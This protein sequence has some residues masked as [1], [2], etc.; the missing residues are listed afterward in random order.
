M[1]RGPTKKHHRQ[2]MPGYAFGTLTCLATETIRSRASAD[3]PLVLNIEPTNFCN[4]KCYLCAGR[5]KAT[6]PR[7]FM[8]FDIFKEIIDEC[9]EHR[10]LH[11]LNLH[12]D[13]ESFLHPRIFDMIRYAKNSKCAG[14]I[15][16]NTNGTLLDRYEPKMVLESGLDDITIS[17]D[18]LLP[19]TYARIKRADSLD[20]VVANTLSLLQA[21]FQMKIR[22]PRIRVKIMEFID[23]KDEI[24]SFVEF[25]K[26]KADEVQVTGAHDWS[27]AIDGLHVTDECPDVRWPCSLLWYTLA[28]NW[29]GQVS[30]CNLDWDLSGAV[31]NVLYDNIESIWRGQK[32]RVIRRAALEGKYEPAVCGKC[33]VW[34][35]GEDMTEWLREQ[36]EYL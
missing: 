5:Q 19:E 25:W 14:T 11:M 15:H 12:K 32:I 8:N 9:S 1:G 33:V 26:D 16:V 7:G 27:G 36:K 24:G 13:G 21:K 4:L 20:A 3:F 28:V 31:G 6:R 17:I 35:G 22:R 34:A 23:T 30:I 29:D 18:A 2:L 10:Q